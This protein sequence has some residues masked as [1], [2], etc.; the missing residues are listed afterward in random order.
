VNVRS[1]DG[2]SECVSAQPEPTAIYF[3]GMSS[4]RHQVRLAFKDRLE[5]S[6]PGEAAIDW[7]YADIRR[8][9]D[10]PGILRLTCL[11]APMLARLE[12]RDPALAAELISRCTRLD[13]NVP[14]RH[15]VAAIVGWSLAAA[16][17][18]VVVLL[19]GVPL[20]ADRLTPLV[21]PSF[22][23]RLGEVADRQ[24]AALF[25]GKVCNRGAGAQVF[26]KLVNAAQEW[27]VLKAIQPLIWHLDIAGLWARL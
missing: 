18:I 14:G 11:T 17:S 8:D 6:E 5:F 13:E 27:A 20:A 21:P 10:R 2:G 9:D 4:R 24:V 1:V 23:R 26:A 3:D 25:G 7:S 22:E 12:I 15:G 16:I 19:L